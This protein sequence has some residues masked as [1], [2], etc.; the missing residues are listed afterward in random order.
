MTRRGRTVSEPHGF[1]LVE[2]VTVLVLIGI[3]ATVAGPPLQRMRS[4]SALQNGRAAITA[5]LARAR[6]AST[7]WGGPSLLSIDIA[8][9]RLRVKMDTSA[10]GEN[11]DTLVVSTFDLSELGV[12]IAANHSAVCF[13]SRGVGTTGA[14]CPQS[15]T[16]IVL[17]SGDDQDTVYINAAGRVWH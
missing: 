11:G 2:L 4:R 8:D 17:S 6:S 16:E 12:T 9:Q 10:S 7:R 5:Q 13:D 1:S 14:A 3:A 15:G